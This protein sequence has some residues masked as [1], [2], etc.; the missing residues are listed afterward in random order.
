MDGFHLIV[1]GFDQESLDRHH[2]SFTTDGRES[3]EWHPER[4]DDELRPRLEMLKEPY[5]E[6]QNG[7]HIIDF[8]LEIPQTPSQ[9]PAVTKRPAS[10]D[11]ATRHRAQKAF[12]SS[13][14]DYIFDD[15]L[16]PP[17]I[18]GSGEVFGDTPVQKLSYSDTFKGEPHNVLRSQ[19]MDT[20]NSSAMKNDEENVMEVQD[21]NNM[22]LDDFE[23][24]ITCEKGAA[25]RR[26]LSDDQQASRRSVQSAFKK[27]LDEQLKREL[28]SRE[29]D[30]AIRQRQLPSMSL[31]CQSQLILDRNDGSLE[32]A[33]SKVWEGLASLQPIHA[34]L[35]AST[36]SFCDENQPDQQFVLRRND[37]ASTHSRLEAPSKMS[38]ENKGTAVLTDQSSIERNWAE[39]MPATFGAHQVIGPVQ[40][41]TRLG[42]NLSAVGDSS[43]KLVDKRRVDSKQVRRTSGLLDLFP[44]YRKKKNDV[45]SSLI[46][47][48]HGVD[49]RST[50]DGEDVA[51]KGLP[52]A[53]VK[54]LQDRPNTIGGSVGRRVA[55]E[56]QGMTT[57]FRPDLNKKKWADLQLWSIEPA[58]W[59]DFHTELAVNKRERKKQN[60]I[61]EL[62][63]TEKHY[64]QVLIILQQVYQEGLRIKN[65]LSSEQRAELIPPVLDALLDFHLNLLRLLCAKRSEKPVVDTIST[66]IYTE[67]EKTERCKA[68]VLHAYVEFLSKKTQC[69]KLYEEWCAKDSDLRKFFDK[70]ENDPKFKDRTFKMCLLLV[71]QRVT[72]YPVLLS[73]LLKLESEQYKEETFRA[74]EATKTVVYRIN[75]ELEELELNKQW[76]AIRSRIDRSSLGKITQDKFLTYD[77]LAETGG[78]GQRRILNIAKAR[79]SNT[80]KKSD[81]GIDVV[82]LLF[83]DYLILLSAPVSGKNKYVFCDCGSAGCP[84]I[85]LNTLILRD[86]PRKTSV[87]VVMDQKPCFDLFVLSFATK[88]DLEQWKY[89]IEAAKGSQPLRSLEDGSRKEESRAAQDESFVL[90]TNPEDVQYNAEMDKWE[91]EVRKHFELRNKEEK[92][93]A[94]YLWKRRE[95]FVELRNLVERIP[96]KSDTDEEKKK[97]VVEKV[98]RDIWERFKQSRKSRRL[99]MVH[100][101][102]LRLWEEGFNP[103]FDTVHDS[104]IHTSDSNSSLEGDEK[105]L[106]PKRTSTFHGTSPHRGASETPIRRRTTEP[107]LSTDRRRIDNGIDATFNE[108]KFSKIPLGL[109]E[110]AQRAVERLLRE[111]IECHVENSQLRSEN[112]MLQIQLAA[113]KT[114]RLETAPTAV[115]EAMRKKLQD[116]QKAEEAFQK[117]VRHLDDRE[118]AVEERE[119]QVE[120]QF[121]TLCGIMNPDPPVTL[122]RPQGATRPA[123]MSGVTFRSGSAINERSP[124]TVAQAGPLGKSSSSSSMPL[125]LVEKTSKILRSKKN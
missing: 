95:W 120:E 79:Y 57:E 108:E 32:P 88:N 99:S 15:D 8:P 42:H 10:A 44:S 81:E 64:C 5:E 66:I 101:S 26:F 23:L 104:S 27:Q 78:V 109:S 77:E 46:G 20:A 18:V 105:R 94:S 7:H 72:K 11:M 121:N 63:L 40:R 25:H 30:V 98:K 61:F 52:D 35:S 76:D 4:G 19:L 70:Y 55:T 93:A 82:L 100:D 6:K 45:H 119:K 73:Q 54:A 114:R 3:L 87:F 84:V 118:K 111:S 75:K 80:T 86:I 83:S 124:V 29:G 92:D 115:L 103:Y 69:E 117:R 91:E 68:A 21:S 112:A 53:L 47:G 13:N 74:V 110:S 43:A 123:S 33:P 116:L 122:H 1:L 89:A 97:E 107:E 41:P 28:E 113:L 14:V 48:K 60:V 38:V 17:L 65:L 9:T 85:A 39:L 24:P 62:Y 31:R 67:F 49:R 36:P 125:H 106:L 90:E 34:N 50:V 96:V 102:A 12:I 58:S 22:E 37:E 2:A 56:V 71:A 16:M 59:S 51:T